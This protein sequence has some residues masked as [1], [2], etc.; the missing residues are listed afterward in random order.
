MNKKLYVG[1]LSYDVEKK[2]LEQLFTSIGSVDT[3]NL[4]MDQYSGRAKGFG[5]VEMAT[6][7]DANSAMEK[8]NGSDFMGRTLKVNLAKERAPRTEYNNRY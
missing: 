7:A 2:D 3:V 1:N 4:I 6:A 8:L 5:F